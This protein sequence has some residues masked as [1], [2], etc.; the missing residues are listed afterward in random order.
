MASQVPFYDPGSTPKAQIELMQATESN[1]NF[2][3]IQNPPKVVFR[4]TIE[5]TSN[6]GE[7]TCN[8]YKTIFDDVKYKV[9][10][11]K[12]SA[13]NSILSISKSRNAMKKEENNKIRTVFSGKTKDRFSKK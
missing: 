11:K 8:K 9:N 7:R 3:T 13:S 12:N 4:T 2:R 6:L 10:Y 5:K 1:S